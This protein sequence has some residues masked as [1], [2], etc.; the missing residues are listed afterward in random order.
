MALLLV[1]RTL[2]RANDGHLEAAGHASD[3]AGPLFPPLHRNRAGTDGCGL[4]P[5]AVYKLVRG[6]SA[7][8]GFQIG[9]HALCATAALAHQADIARVQKWLGHA[10]IATTRL[11]D[12]RKTRP[13]D[14]PTFKVSY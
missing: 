13:E 2:R 9:A 8:L 12:H 5:D 14:S 4:A 11:Y 10:N 7:A 3:D 1:E 6:H